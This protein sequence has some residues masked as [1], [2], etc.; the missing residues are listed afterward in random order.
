MNNEKYNNYNNINRNNKE[1]YTIMVSEP[2]NKSYQNIF[3]DDLDGWD[4]A[5]EELS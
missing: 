1:Q 2:M 4:E 5:I 3:S